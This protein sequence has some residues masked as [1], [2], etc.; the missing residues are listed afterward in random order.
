MDFVSI[1]SDYEVLIRNISQNIRE[2]RLKCGLTQAQMTQ[3][4][5]D[6]KNYQKLEY[7]KHQFSLHTVFR[8]SRA[9]NCPIET[10]ICEPKTR[11]RPKA[12]R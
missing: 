1:E 9:F 4:G 5:F 10:L 8:L 2:Q 7:G 3:F 11:R 6:I 12:K